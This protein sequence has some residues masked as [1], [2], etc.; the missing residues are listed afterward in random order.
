MA[1]AAEPRLRRHPPTGAPLAGAAPARSG[2]GIAARALPYPKQLAWLLTRPAAELTGGERAAVAR[3]GQG[4]EAAPVAALVRR[5]AGLVRGGGTGRRKALRAPLTALKCWLSDALRSGVRAV[6]AFAA[7]LQQDNAAVGAA[8]T[9]LW[10]SGQAEERISKLK[11]IKRQTC[12]RASFDLLRR[13]V[14]LPA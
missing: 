4:R 9:K 11:L 8:P 7:G 6:T 13:R 2:E 12:G 10:S 1:R 14:L 5:F 3:V